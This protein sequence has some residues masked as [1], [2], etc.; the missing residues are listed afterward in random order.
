MERT[1]LLKRVRDATAAF[2]LVIL[3]G[4]FNC[5]AGRQLDALAGGNLCL[6]ELGHAPLPPGTMTGLAKDFRTPICIDHAFVSPGLVCHHAYTDQDPANPW[7]DDPP[8]L[9]IAECP[10]DHVPVRFVFRP[11]DAPAASPGLD[12]IRVTTERGNPSWQ[13]SPA[14]RPPPPPP[15][16]SASSVLASTMS[17]SGSS[18]TRSPMGVLNPQDQGPPPGASAPAI[19]TVSRAPPK[20]PP[21]GLYQPNLPRQRPGYFSAPPERRSVAQRKTS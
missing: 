7:G 15:A 11:E 2:S 21:V 14:K 6:S 18:H 8:N 20:G 13:T 17:A 1:E 10:S 19:M 9:P 3:A 12:A 5:S 4:D 16:K